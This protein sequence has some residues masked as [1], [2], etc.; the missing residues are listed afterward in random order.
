MGEV[1]LGEQVSLGR[2]VA[3]KVLRSELALRPGM[4]ERFKREAKLLSA[5]DHPSVVRIIDFGPCGASVCLVMELVD[6]LPLTNE[7]TKGPLLPDRA[8]QL[9]I[10]LAEGLSA[11]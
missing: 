6:G 8:V 5:V 3:V 9:L 1:Y 7:L 2:P 4:I 10:G 11:I